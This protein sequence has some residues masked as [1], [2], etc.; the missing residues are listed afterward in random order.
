[1]INAAICTVGTVQLIKNFVPGK[2]GKVV[3]TII[4]ILIGVGMTLIQRLAPTWV[5]DA[6]LVVDGASLFYDTIYQTFEKR[7]KGE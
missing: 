3:W 2:G 4:T 6:I 1:M 7:F 5:M